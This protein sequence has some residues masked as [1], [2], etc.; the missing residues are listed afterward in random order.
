MTGTVI[1]HFIDKGRGTEKF[2]S[3]PR[4]HTAREGGELGFEPR[5]TDSQVTS[6]EELLEG[7]R[8]TGEGRDASELVAG[9]EQPVPMG[10]SL[11]MWP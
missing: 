11:L 7:G 3:L 8:S 1:P 9:G 2:S 4:S 6:Q 5:Q 10:T